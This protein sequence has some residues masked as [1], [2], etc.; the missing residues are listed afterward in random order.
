MKL[1]VEE[2]AD[3]TVEAWAAIASSLINSS[4]RHLQVGVSAWMNPR[5]Y[6]DMAFGRVPKSLRM[7]WSRI[8]D[9]FVRAAA[10]GL[11]PVHRR[12]VANAKRLGG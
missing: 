10:K 6:R 9:D 4:Q 5:T 1:M 7:P 12:A 3:A 2:K 8:S 11:D